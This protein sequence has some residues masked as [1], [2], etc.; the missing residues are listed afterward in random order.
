[1]SFYKNCLECGRHVDLEDQ[2]C[3]KCGYDF[4]SQPQVK[5]I[6][7]YCEKEIHLSDFFTTRLDKKGHKRIVGFICENGPQSK[8]MW[9]CPLCGKIL[10]FSNALSGH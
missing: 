10:G 6:C 9:Y 4:T 5:P 3:P 1:M 8:Q 2:I 7:P